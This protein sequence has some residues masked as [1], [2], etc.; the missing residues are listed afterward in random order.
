[1]DFFFDEEEPNDCDG[2]VTGALCIMIFPFG[3]ITPHPPSD[4][5]TLPFGVN[6]TT[7]YICRKTL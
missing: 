6:I 4:M 5:T 3:V 1:M 7:W 2:V